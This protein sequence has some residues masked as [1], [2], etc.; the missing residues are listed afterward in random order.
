MMIFIFLG[1][2][3]ASG[4]LT[5]LQHWSKLT[6]IQNQINKTTAA[7]SIFPVDQSVQHFY[8]KLEKTP[9]LNTTTSRLSL[10]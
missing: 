6:Q 4:E 3:Q 5:G 9:F 8:I 10:Q 1:L 7:L 2:R